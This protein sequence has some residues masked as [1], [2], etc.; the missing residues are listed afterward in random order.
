MRVKLLRDE[1][2]ATVRLVYPS[3]LDE[4]GEAI[5]TLG[6]L[7]VPAGDDGPDADGGV[8][9]AIHGS[10][11]VTTESQRAGWQLPDLCSSGC[12]RVVDESE[13]FGLLRAPADAPPPTRWDGGPDG[14]VSEA[15]RALGAPDTRLE[16]VLE[17][18]GR[19]DLPG[20]VCE[21]LRR[22]LRRALAA[23]T[24]GKVV[25]RAQRVL[26]LPWCRRSP[27]R[28]DAA[29]VSLA[30][31][32]AHG[33]HGWARARLIEALAACPQSSGL[34]T[35]EGA[36][37]GRGVAAA[38]APLALVVRPAA[39]AAP[40]PCLA[41]PPGTGKTS[42]AAAAA[43]ALGRARVQVMLGGQDAERLL[44]GVEDG[45]TGRIVE[46]LC[47]TGV[48]NLV[49]ILE[50]IDRVDDEAAGVLLD[51]LDPQ[52]RR[53]FRDAYLDVPFDLCDVLWIATATDPGRIPAPVRKWLAVIELAGYSTEEKLDIAQRDLLTRPFDATAPASWLSPAPAEVEPAG[54]AAGPAV[55]ADLS[56]SSLWDLEASPPPPPPGIPGEDWRMA[57]CTGDVV[58]DAAA[59]RRVIE[60]HTNEA[61]VAELNTKLA[62]VCRRVVER[63][64]PGHRGT[65]MVTPAVVR[66]VLGDGEALPAAVRAAI[67]R[68][69]RRLADGSSDTDAAT[70]TN[71]WIACLEKLPWT[72]RSEAP[73]DLARARAA[74][75]AGHAGLDE[76][77]SCIL[78]HLAVWR[79]NPRSGAVLCLAGPP[80][81]GKTS[82][83][84]CTAEA[85]GRGFVRLA[86]GGLRD[87]SD[88]RG[89]NRTWKD[90]Q[91]GWILRE[92]RRVGTKDPVVVLDEID[93][94]G[95]AP[96]AV[97]LEVL[98]PAQNAHFR[99]AF[100]ELPFDLS[101]VLF[102]TT[103]NEVSRI[104]PA[105]RDRLEVVELPGY[106][107]DEK[108]AIGETHLVA[109]QNRA[110]GLTAPPV[111]FTRGALRRIIR[112]HTSEQGVR[113]F[114]RRL[115][116]ICRKVALGLET[117]DASLVRGRV[118]VRQVHAFLGAPRIDHT[119]GVDRLG[120]QLDAPSLPA[121]VRE[122]GR[123]VLT[124]LSAWSPT[125]PE[126]GRA[127]EYQRCLA[128]V[129]WTVRAET[130]LD[131]AR[132]RALVDAGHAGHAGVKE[133]LLDYVAVRL[134]NPDAPSG[135]L[136]L[137]GPPGV[138]KS[139]LARLVAAALGRPCAWVDCDALGSATAVH[140]SRAERPGRIVEA[141]RRAGVRNP[142]FVLDEVD[143]LDE[144]GG[145]S[146]ALLE[147]VDP[148]RGA[149]FCDRYLDLPINLSE[150]LFVATASRLG[151]VPAGLRE[152]MR[153]VELPGY[154]ETE[155]RVIAARSLLPGLLRLH[156][157]TAGEVDVTDEAVGVII[158]GYTR[159]AGVWRLAAAL[160]EVCVRVVRR[161][162]EG[163]ESR[164]VVTPEQLAGL[165]GAPV[166]PASEVAGRTG[167][168][169][170]AVGLCWTTSGGGEVLFVEVTT[171]AG[172]GALTLTGRQ[173]E[174][175][176]ESARGVL[177]WLRVN[178]G[179]YGVDPGFHRD[180]DIHLH[181]DEGPA[182]GA[183]A[184]VAMASA[185]VSAFTGR[186]IR[187]DLAMTG[188]VTLSGQVLRVGGIKEKLLAAHRGGLA[189]VILPR[190]N[191]KE[192]DED[193]GEELRRAVEVHYVTRVD[194]LLELAL[195]PSSAS[196]APAGRVS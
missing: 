143:R 19:V 98:D 81:V 28:W 112:D 22:E 39:A 115:Q 180:I 63:R 193:L 95:T 26:R 94:I 155:K 1:D 68:E 103:A 13:A 4:Y 58:F 99:D 69:R 31:E 156:G 77:K 52:R 34:L 5:E 168:P 75:D 18:L 93:K 104:P 78:E 163:D 66:E 32:R 23:R 59:I 153:V 36:R 141:L 188:E 73:S 137:L 111:R 183:S 67:A 170:V 177:S 10:Y 49:F 154:T 44:H 134:A 105:L 124:R 120:A 24:V 15:L 178:A 113:Q 20:G 17:A 138:G 174:V 126:H 109:A 146:A 97:L 8:D 79:R 157:L 76:A 6:A 159:E 192:V 185:L 53:A 125:D 106:S 27:A 61:G 129:P 133:R 175:M 60:G 164:V 30:L 102:I 186:P 37:D 41:G 40:V 130:T 184:G 56:V 122:R 11:L 150:A 64:P 173:G 144:S 43:A 189:G 167:R 3:T 127:R 195:E 136:C 162:A 55:V 114:A 116:A 80:G 169:G 149:A 57:A 179:R 151:S 12:A 45:V 74:L 107:E 38:G 172:S 148:M 194:E 16:Q 123:Q 9:V 121:A 108:V 142:V 84:Q 196:A 100:V 33:G 82:L 171:M 83:A 132:S 25:D 131:L 166:Y 181:V 91:S 182:D 165:L 62:A 147:A 85:L 87:E 48:N 86:C 50:G 72:R 139:S 191:Q 90:A 42:L 145:A 54:R 35:V 88:L 92:L 70:R 29:G 46:G 101:E 128:G 21:T 71:D 118:T 160:G 47:E 110:A 2:G 152:R 140:G 119:D 89:H 7:A 51:V 96:A 117:G 65:E 161:R 14:P 187:G 135:V 176:Q 190:G 158:R